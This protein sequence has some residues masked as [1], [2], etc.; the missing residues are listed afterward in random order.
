MEEIGPKR[1]E[2]RPTGP[3]Q[4]WSPIHLGQHGH[5]TDPVTQTQ[6]QE[7]QVERLMAV[8]T[9]GIEGSSHESVAQPF[10]PGKLSACNRH[11]NQPQ[12]AIPDAH[13]RGGGIGQPSTSSCP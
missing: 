8:E 4:V 13:A 6:L 10:I 12:E 11:L 1:P 7:I 5:A 3:I 9:N 2:A